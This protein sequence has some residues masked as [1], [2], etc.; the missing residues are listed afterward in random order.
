[1]EDT[2]GGADSNRLLTDKD[3][4][5]L[6]LSTVLY[7]LHETNPDNGLVRDKTDPNAP[8]SVAAVG[9]A[10]ATIPVVV[11]RGVAVGSSHAASHPLVNSLR[12]CGASGHQRPWS[13]PRHA[14]FGQVTEGRLTRR[15]YKGVRS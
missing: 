13:P 14:G 10:L 7:Y 11:E 12:V 3:L 15:S 9:M 8:V 5:L 2:S 6:Q 4:G 1:M